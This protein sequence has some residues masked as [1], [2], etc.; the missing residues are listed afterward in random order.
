MNDEVLLWLLVMSGWVS[1]LFAHRPIRKQAR[2]TLASPGL[3]IT[4][5]SILT[6]EY[7]FQQLIA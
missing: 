1:T 3:F 5:Y 6:F 7:K 2:D 4:S